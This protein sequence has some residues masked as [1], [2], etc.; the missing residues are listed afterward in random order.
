MG[1]CGPDSE[2]SIT[3]TVHDFA[4]VTQKG[5]DAINDYSVKYI[6]LN[7][8]KP[9]PI[10]A[11]DNNENKY[12]HLRCRKAHT[13]NRRYEQILKRKH[14]RVSSLTYELRSDAIFY[15]TDCYLCGEVGGEMVD[16]EKDQQSCM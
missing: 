11:Y 13:N 2:D 1:T 8:V 15:H 7:Q 6:E 12:V 5:L 16:Q 3:F 14:D 9:I 10:Q 4:C